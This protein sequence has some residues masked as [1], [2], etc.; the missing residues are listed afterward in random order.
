MTK[1]RYVL[2]FLFMFM[3]CTGRSTA[4]DRVIVPGERIGPVTADTPES[5][6]V[7]ALGREAATGRAVDIGE[8]YCVPGTVLFPESVDAMEIAW[9]DSARTKPAFARIRSDGARWTTPAGVRIGMTLEELERINGAPVAFSGFGWDYGGTA[10]W[11]ETDGGASSGSLFLVL[12][13]DSS[14]E[15]WVREHPRY[16]EIIGERSVMSDHPLIREMTIRVEGMSLRW[17][18]PA[19]PGQCPGF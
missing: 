7:E 8:G 17:T 14:S 18:E 19:P 3:A 9:S 5:E 16:S 11:T 2:G 4:P 10:T 1:T 6:L 15:A 13:P 12:A